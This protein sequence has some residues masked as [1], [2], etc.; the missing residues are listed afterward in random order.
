MR[1]FTGSHLDIRLIDFW[2]IPI[3][4]VDAFFSL[5]LKKGRED[6]NVRNFDD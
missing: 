2:K 5:E 3:D 4:I 6:R 1:R